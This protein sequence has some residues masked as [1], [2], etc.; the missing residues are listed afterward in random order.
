MRRITMVTH[1]VA[2][3]LACG[4]VGAGGCGGELDAE[5]PVMPAADDRAAIDEYIR[6]LGTLPVADEQVEEG[7][8]TA[9]VQEGDYS[10]SRQNFRETR[11]YDKLVAYAAN[12]ESLWPGAIV[13]GDSIYEGLFTPIVMDR[14]P[15]SFSV[16]LENLS[17]AKSAT[18]DKPSLSEFREALGWIL[19]SEVTGATPANLYAEIEEVH[20]K[21]QLAVALGADVDWLTGSVATSFQFGEENVKSRFLVKY[22]QSYYTVDVDPPRRPSD[23]FA[24]SVRLAD[25]EAAM[26]A[27]RPPVY[28]SSITYGRMILFTFESEYSAQ[29]MGAAL[30]FVYRGGVRVSG[31]VSVTYEE[32]LSK[33]KITAYILG[34]S[35]GMAAQSIDSYEKLLDLVRSG[36]NYSKD[37][38]GAPIAYKLAYL[39]DNAPARLSFTSEYEV[40][41]CERVGQR[42]L[43]KLKSFAVESAGGDAGDDLEL[44]G[45]VW[46]AAN[47]HRTLFDRGSGDWVRIGQG[48]IWPPAGGLGEVIVQVTPRPG[49]AIQ[50]GARL[51]DADG[52]LNPDD[53]GDEIVSLPYETG[54]RR[55][56]SVLLTGDGARV[57]VTFELQPI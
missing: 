9:A 44:Y 33:S 5:G 22:V 14:A 36:G 34:G 31:D 27:G 42:V 40:K 51:R 39:A 57:R 41:T 1:L 25:V 19:S 11:Q 29:E 10:C 47:D 6:G 24:S 13:A 54:W 26:P 28:V 18:M 15:L 50:L 56:A 8:A 17:G 46:A 30:D 45:T 21:E 35:G 48:Q 53:I 3:G 43:V 37:S 38:P 20:S 49:S 23:V 52:V 12:S 4:G 16:S 55:E 7:T 2:C 32:M